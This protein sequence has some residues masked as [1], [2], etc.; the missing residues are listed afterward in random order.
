MTLLYQ[1]LYCIYDAYFSSSDW[2]FKTIAANSSFADVRHAINLGEKVPHSP[3]VII[4]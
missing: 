1:S 4:V 3:L 2:L